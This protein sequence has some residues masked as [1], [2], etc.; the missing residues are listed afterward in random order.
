MSATLRNPFADTFDQLGS[1]LFAGLTSYMMAQARHQL[2]MTVRIKE[3]EAKALAYQTANAPEFEK[4]CKEITRTCFQ[5]FDEQRRRASTNAVRQ[6][7]TLATN[8]NG[9]WKEGEGNFDPDRP[10]TADNEKDQ[11]RNPFRIK[12]MVLADTRGRDAKELLALAQEC[13][14]AAKLVPA[15]DSLAYKHYRVHFYKRAGQLANQASLAELGVTGFQEA[16]KQPAQAAKTA[17]KAW[18]LYVDTKTDGD[19]TGYGLHQRLLAFAYGGKL[20]EALVLVKQN[21]LSKLR[22]GNPEFWFDVSRILS[23][24]GGLTKERIK[25]NPDPLLV[26]NLRNYRSSAIFC[27]RMS[28]CSGLK[29]TDKLKTDPDLEW[30]RGET[31]DQFDKLI[32]LSNR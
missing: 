4:D 5:T 30:I 24:S 20:Y 10:L 17:Q 1:G 15:G 14:E 23:A 9:V 18:K 26:S 13:L 11:P 27:L 28:V 32:G 2:Q 19:P 29:N 21:D 8:Y 25:R 22:S 6:M 3:A 12:G 7:A 16:Q 31:G